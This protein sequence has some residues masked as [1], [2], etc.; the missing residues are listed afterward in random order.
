MKKLISLILALITVMSVATVITGAADADVAETSATYYVSNKPYENVA[1][2]TIIGYLGDVDGSGEVSIL[3][4]T[5]IQ[6]SLASIIAMNSNAKLLADVDRGGDVSIL[7]AT[8]IQCFIAKIATTAKVAHTLYTKT[9]TPSSNIF[10]Q[11]KSYTIANG[12]YYK[13]SNWYNVYDSSTDIDTGLVYM[14]DQNEIAISINY[15]SGSTSISL[16]FAI[17]I[18]KVDEYDYNSFNATKMVGSDI[19]YDTFGQAKQLKSTDKKLVLTDLIYNSETLKFSEVEPE[20][21]NLITKG[22][23]KIEKQSNGKIT[24][25]YQL[26]G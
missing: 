22:F 12:Y 13:D 21:Q 6:L 4:A 8:D 16:F 3:D 2:A 11:V 5:Q 15:Y 26:F 17:P 20:L 19:I 23:E 1:N 10:E 18:D 24:N 25:L 14:V 7:D 9:S